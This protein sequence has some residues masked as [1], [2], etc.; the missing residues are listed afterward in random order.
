MSHGQFGFFDRAQQLEKIYQL[1]NFLPTLN[2]LIDWE[3]FRST[4]NKVREKEHA[5]PGGRPPFDVVLMFKILV[6]KSM[7]NLSDDQTELQIRDRISFQDFLGL[8][9]GDRIAD[10]AYV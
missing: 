4:L 9:R 8:N 10:A 6:L 2:T 1:N 5:G 7:Y 3:I